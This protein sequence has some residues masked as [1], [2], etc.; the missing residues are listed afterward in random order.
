MEYSERVVM[1]FG[2]AALRDLAHLKKSCDIIESK[3]KAGVEVI[4]V[5]SA[6]GKTTDFL[7]SQAK[8][9]MKNP[10]KRE[11][12]MLL[13]AGERM[14]MAL[15]SMELE[16]RGLRA[17]SF[18]GSQAGV[19]TTD[20]HLDAKI[21]DVKPFRI[22]E[23]L[24]KG[25]IPVI[26]GFQ[27]V[28]THKEITTLGRGG[29][30]TTAVALAIA[31]KAS[32]VEFYKDVPGVFTQDPK[33]NQNATCIEELDY[34]EAYKVI[35]AA[36]KKLI[37][38]RAILLAQKNFI[39]LFVQSFEKENLPQNQNGSWIRNKLVQKSLKLIF[40]SDEELCSN[41]SL[42]LTHSYPG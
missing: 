10:P 36:E 40:E 29:S 11:L 23:S 6:M 25:I 19:I 14:S 21:L 38:P 3:A 27:G 20:C 35:A 18:T 8:E 28:S 26:A 32:V 1:K 7:L 22:I 17:Q 12:D 24:Q 2:G 34:E 39:P 42:N 33:V 9:I 16:A 4:I 30:D 13:S 31:L 41:Y 5:A 37:H 15:V